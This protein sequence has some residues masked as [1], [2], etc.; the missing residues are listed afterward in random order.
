[1]NLIYFIKSIDSK[2]NE[3]T[4]IKKLGKL[5]EFRLQFLINLFKK[6]QN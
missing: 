3:Q 2:L 6:M 1:M 4:I 5:F